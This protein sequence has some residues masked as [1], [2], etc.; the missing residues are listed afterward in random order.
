MFSNK[1]L[2]IISSVTNSIVNTRQLQFS[3]WFGIQETP[4]FQLVIPMVAFLGA[5]FLIGV[6][7]YIYNRLVI[8]QYVPKN[9]VLQPF[10][11]GLVILSLVGG[12]FSFF[13]YSR[14]SFLGTRFFLTIFVIVILAWILY[15]AY[16]WRKKVPSEIIKYE[17][18]IVKK[19]YLRKSR[20]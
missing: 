1:V 13:R 9:R 5:S 8:R 20:A 10:S 14:V 2:I 3:Y 19:R 15:F 18:R 11:I 12:I 6:T 4:K 16:L 17:T 7:A